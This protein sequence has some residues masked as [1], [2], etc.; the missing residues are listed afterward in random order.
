MKFQMEHAR[1]VESYWQYLE[2]PRQS[3][4]DETNS[5]SPNSVASRNVPEMHHELLGPS[6]RMI[7]RK[8][9]GNEMEARLQVRFN[10]ISGDFSRRFESIT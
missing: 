6:C 1:G 9:V 5:A 4:F 10:C 8:I 7:E 2:S 3:Y